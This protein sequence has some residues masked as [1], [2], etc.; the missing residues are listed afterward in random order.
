MYPRRLTQS[1][2]SASSTSVD[3]TSSTQSSVYFLL[4]CSLHLS[5]S[6]KP[7]HTHDVTLRAAVAK[8]LDGLAAPWTSNADMR[9]MIDPRLLF[10]S[11]FLK[12]QSSKSIP[13]GLVGGLCSRVGVNVMQFPCGHGSYSVVCPTRDGV[14]CVTRTRLWPR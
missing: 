5:G 9:Y 14:R 2:S 8:V 7:N 13:R 10:L 11:L 6:C 12:S 1:H 3:S 4:L